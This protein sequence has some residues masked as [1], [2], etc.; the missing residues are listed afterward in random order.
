MSGLGSD[1]VSEFVGLRAAGVAIVRG[2]TTSDMERVG[3]HPA[4]GPLRV[5]EVIA[6]W[7]H[8]D[9][10]HIRQLLEVSQTRVWSQMG[11]ARRFSLEDL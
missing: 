3:M 5:G 8:H 10:N 4:V 7:V 6:E 2:L 11:N 1:L 9:R